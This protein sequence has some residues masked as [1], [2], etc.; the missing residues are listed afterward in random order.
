MEL[1]TQV[2]IHRR[3]LVGTGGAWQ[4]LPLPELSGGPQQGAP[5]LEGVSLSLNLRWNLTATPE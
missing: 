5:L 1:R 3:L 2:G 4:C